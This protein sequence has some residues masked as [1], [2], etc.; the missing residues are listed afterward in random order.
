M[1]KYS[2]LS[3]A[4]CSPRQVPLAVY[5]IYSPSILANKLYSR[6]T[7]SVTFL[8]ISAGAQLQPSSLWFFCCT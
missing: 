7:A 4:L 8:A 2:S 6:T 5:I 1:L 3:Y